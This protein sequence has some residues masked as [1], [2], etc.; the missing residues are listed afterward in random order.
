MVAAGTRSAA[1]GKWAAAAGKGPVAAGKGHGSAGSGS[2]VCL[3]QSGHAVHWIPAPSRACVV[4][5]P[6]IPIGPE[7]VLEAVTA[8]DGRSYYDASPGA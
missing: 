3:E 2:G 4:L 5:S 1:A 8:K 6:I 7:N